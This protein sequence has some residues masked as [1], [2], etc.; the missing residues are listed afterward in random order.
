MWEN[1]P[2][3]LTEVGKTNEAILKYS[4]TKFSPEEKL[5]DTENFMVIVK[6]FIL[7]YIIRMQKYSIHYLTL[8]GDFFSLFSSTWSSEENLLTNEIVAEYHRRKER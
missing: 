4:L 5:I 2:D 7:H 8:Y 3:N 6:H 1:H